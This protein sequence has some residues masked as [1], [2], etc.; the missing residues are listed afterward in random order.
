MKP[1]RDI[2]QM[3]FLWRQKDGMSDAV[4]TNWVDELKKYTERYIDDEKFKHICVDGELFWDTMS[5]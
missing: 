1:L 2:S 3:R 4:G 5:H